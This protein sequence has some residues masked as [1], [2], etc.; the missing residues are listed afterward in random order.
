MAT[1]ASSI[2]RGVSLSKIRFKLRFNSIQ[3]AGP[4]ANQLVRLCGQ[5]ISQRVIAKFGTLLHFLNTGI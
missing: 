3:F 4:V 1:C 2:S 5:K